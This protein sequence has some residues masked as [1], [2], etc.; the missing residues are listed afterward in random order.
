MSRPIGFPPCLGRA[1]SPNRW[2]G[3]RCVHSDPRRRHESDTA[4]CLG[5][6]PEVAVAIEGHGKDLDFAS[7]ERGRHEWFD[8]SFLQLSKSQA[9]AF[10][11]HADPHG[12]IRTKGHAHNPV[13]STTL[14]L[15]ASIGYVSDAPS[16]QCTSAVWPPSQNPSLPSADI[17]SIGLIG[18][19]SAFPKHLAFPSTT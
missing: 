17:E 18:T 4:P 8:D 5:W 3:H 13:C 12:S 9:R 11:E 19:P 16:R 10:G 1:G 7:I 14:D 6:R 15:S 2:T